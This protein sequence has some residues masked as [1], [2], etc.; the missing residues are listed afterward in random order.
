MIKYIQINEKELKIKAIKKYLPLQKGD[1]QE[2]LSHVNNFK[3]LG[4]NPKINP[5]IGIK[6]FIEWYKQYYKIKS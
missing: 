6:K 5:E 2:T 3:K 1:I 4:Y